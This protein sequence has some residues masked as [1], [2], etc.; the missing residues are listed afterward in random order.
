MLVSGWQVVQCLADPAEFVGVGGA[1][2]GY[3]LEEPLG[4][5]DAGAHRVEVEEAC[6]RA[7][8]VELASKLVSR[9]ARPG[10]GFESR[11]DAPHLADFAAQPGDEVGAGAPEPPPRLR[12]LLRRRPFRSCFA[13]RGPLVRHQMFPGLVGHPRPP[14]TTTPEPGRAIFV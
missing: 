8:R 9:A 2:A 13:A 1:A 14:R 7:E 6:R 12:R 4:L 3:A 5:A 10:V 11:E